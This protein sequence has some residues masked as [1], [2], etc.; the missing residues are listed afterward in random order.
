MKSWAR[1]M[2]TL[3]SGGA[4]AQPTRQP[5]TEYDFE[6]PEMVIVRSAMPGSV[7]IGVWPRPS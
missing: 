6:I 7:A 3:I 4:T 2:P 5:V 1:R